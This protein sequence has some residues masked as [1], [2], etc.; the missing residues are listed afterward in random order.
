[1]LTNLV[2]PDHFRTRTKL[3][4]TDPRNLIKCYIFGR[5]VIKYTCVR[6]YEISCMFS[7]DDDD[8]DRILGG[9]VS[10]EVVAITKSPQLTTRLLAE[11]AGCLLFRAVAPG[12]ASLATTGPYF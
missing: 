10:Y 12:P 9:P 1:M 8:L 2:R 4:V 5:D 3:N 6:M 7:G 11:P